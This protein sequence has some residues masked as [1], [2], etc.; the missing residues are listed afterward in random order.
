MDMRI[1]NDISNFI[2]LEDK[3]EKA[4]AILIPGCSY[5]ETAEKAASL[6]NE[7]YAKIVVPSGLYSIKY[8]KFLGVQSKSEKYDKDYE[9]ECE[10]ITDVLKINGVDAECILEEDMAQYTADN[11]NLT[12]KLLKNNNITLKKAII[13]CR[14]FHARRCLMF[15]QFCF[16]ETKLMI[17][18][19]SNT[20]GEVITK[21]DWYKT[22]D[23]LERVLGEFKR[24]G[25]QFFP[26][27]QRLRYKKAIF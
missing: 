12:K 11:A 21:E 15:Y 10:F 7:G 1:I 23:G 8:G 2:F 13:C 5:P 26:Q 3:I 16:P 4:D 9:T 20:P 14:A 18:P 22:S 19:V 6:W 24:I 27:F 25:T 17:C